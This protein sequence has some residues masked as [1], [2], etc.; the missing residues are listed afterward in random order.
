MTLNKKVL[1]LCAITELFLFFVNPKRSSLNSIGRQFVLKY[2][3]T[4]RRILIGYEKCK[5]E[6]H[7]VE[8]CR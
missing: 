7:L 1:K 3:Y 5:R 8:V 6:Q 2:L 4:S